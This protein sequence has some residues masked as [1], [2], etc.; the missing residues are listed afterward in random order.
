MT[1]ITLKWHLN[2]LTSLIALASCTNNGIVTNI[3]KESRKEFKMD[4]SDHFP[5]EINDRKAY[6]LVREPTTFTEIQYG[7]RIQLLLTKASKEITDF[8]NSLFQFK[9]IIHP[10]DSCLLI[11]QRFGLYEKEKYNDYSDSLFKSCNCFSLPIPDFT[12]LNKYL[13][14]SSYL[15]PE[16]FTIYVIDAK[17]GSF[18]D[19]ICLSQ[20]LGLPESWRNGFSK[21][22]AVSKNRNAI[23]YW[24]DVW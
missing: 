3:L 7:A 12:N 18:M 13:H 19:S 11:I 17:P 16:D 23:I 22:I 15:L 21:G 10:N 4:L 6:M 8:D 14:N 24:L 9:Q 1:H 2:L 5:E 20:G